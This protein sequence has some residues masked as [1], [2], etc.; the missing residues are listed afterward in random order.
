MQ[1]ALLVLQEKNKERSTIEK[2]Y[3]RKECGQN[4]GRGTFCITT[5]WKTKKQ[6]ACLQMEIINKPFASHRITILKAFVFVNKNMNGIISSSQ[7]KK[8]MKNTI[9]K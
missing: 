7:K 2:E 5:T 1:N 8:V 4:F 9:L 6:I 3:G